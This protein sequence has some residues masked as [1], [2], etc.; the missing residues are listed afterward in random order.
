MTTMLLGVVKRGKTKKREK[1]DPILL[2]RGEGKR[3]KI[4]AY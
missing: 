3:G 1:K 2:P 4:C